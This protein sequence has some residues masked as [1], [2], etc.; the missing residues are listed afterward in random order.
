MAEMAHAAWVPGL[1]H[2]LAKSP[3]PGWQQLADACRALGDRWRAAGVETLAVVSTQWYSVLGLQ[4]QVRPRPQGVRVDENW[5]GYE[6]GTI[7]YDF[8]TDTE[9]AHRWLDALR[10]QGFQAR[11]TEHEHFPIDTGLVIALEL[12]DPKHE[13]RIAQV[14]LNL[15]GDADSVERLGRCAAEASAATGR[16]AAALAISGLSSEPLR[17]WI[18]PSQD[19][20]ATPQNERWDRR[21]LELIEAGQVDEVFALREEYARAASADSQ[22]RA[23]GFLR[24][25][26]G[27]RGKAKVHG[28]APVWGTGGAVIEWVSTE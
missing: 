17:R 24:G 10:Q 25:A 27:L 8:Q 9:L 12:L 22:L 7:P 23:L 5:Y 16:R 18:E 3:A 14:S 11:P 13:W 1:P 21:I 19:H 2:L 20:V 6:F 4:V 15:Y 26:A 28:Y